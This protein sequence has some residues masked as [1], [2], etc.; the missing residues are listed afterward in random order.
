MGDAVLLVK[1]FPL[2]ARSGIFWFKGIYVASVSCSWC[3]DTP[4]R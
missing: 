1:T 3:K 4:K 2:P